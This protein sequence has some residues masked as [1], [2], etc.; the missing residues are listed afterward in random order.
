MGVMNW[1][2][3]IRFI[4]NKQTNVFTLNQSKYA[5]DVLDRFAPYYK[6]SSCRAVPMMPGS[7]L[8]PWNDNYYSFLTIDQ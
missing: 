3:G 5:Q 4:Y 2:L 6:N 1:Y 8:S 7:N